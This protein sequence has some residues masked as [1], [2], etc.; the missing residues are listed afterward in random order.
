MV[1]ASRIPAEWM[2]ND[3]FLVNRGAIAE[4][5]VGQELLAYAP[6][7]DDAKLYFWCREKKSSMAEVDY[8]TTVGAQI[9]PIEVKGG[10]TGQLKSFHLLMK[11][12]NITLGIRISQQP[13]HFDGRILTVPFYMV[14]EIPRLVK[15]LHLWSREASQ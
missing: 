2:L 11:E 10:S 4:Q 9:I 5:F 15:L 3:I 6:S 8:I 14:G 13:L 1:Y 7:Y 12:K